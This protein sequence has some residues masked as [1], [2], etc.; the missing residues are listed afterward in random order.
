MNDYQKGKEY[1]ELIHDL[2]SDLMLFELDQL[3]SAAKG[4]VT[5]RE[6]HTIEHIGHLQTASMKQLADEARV[7]QSSMTTMIDKLIRKG[8]VDRTMDRDDKR[9]VRVKLTPRGEI[10]HEEH[11]LL[12]EQI[13]K[14]WLNIL[15]ESEQAILLRLLRKISEQL[16]E[17][18]RKPDS[19]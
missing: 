11:D 4:N 12:H 17:A 15:D 9:M 3:N 10:L 7:K 18:V 5:F 19:Q 16:P 1:Y 13:T 2:Y 14:T 8:Y 6:M